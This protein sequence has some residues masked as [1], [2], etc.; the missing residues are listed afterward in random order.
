MQTYAL[1]LR[2]SAG[3]CL[4]VGALHLVLGV[5]ADVLLGARLAAEAVAAPTLVRRVT[6][7]ANER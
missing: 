5:G 6:H 7:A 1:V 4:L 3:V 2:L